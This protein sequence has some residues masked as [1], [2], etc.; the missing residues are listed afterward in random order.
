MKFHLINQKNYQRDFSDWDG[1]EVFP[2]SEKIYLR[3]E[4][5]KEE[6]WEK[7]IEIL[8]TP[9][10]HIDKNAVAMI[11]MGEFY[12]EKDC[13]LNEYG[14]PKRGAEN[15]RTVTGLVLDYDG[16]AK[17][18]D[19][20][21]Q[22]KNYEFFAYTSFNH[23]IRKAYIPVTESLLL[24][25]KDFQKGIKIEIE[26]KTIE[27]FRVILPFNT[28]YDKDEIAKRRYSLEQ[29]F[30]GADKTTF[31]LSRHFYVYSSAPNRLNNAWCYHNKGKFF[32]IIN[33]P[34]SRI[35]Y[36]TIGEPQEITEKDKLDV[37]N[38][39]QT[40]TNNSVHYNK[41]GWQI[42]NYC[43]TI[44]I[45]VDKCWELL[46]DKFEI[47]SSLTNKQTFYRIYSSGTLGKISISGFKKYIL[48]NGGKLDGVKI[49]NNRVKKLLEIEP[50]N[51]ER[52]HI[53]EIKREI[54]FAI[55]K[56]F[57]GQRILLK[58]E[59][60]TG[61]TK[62]AI[63]AI[64]NHFKKPYVKVFK[65]DWFAYNK[66]NMIDVYHA[67]KRNGINAII[68]YGRD[69]WCKH[70]VFAIKNGP[71]TAKDY[72]LYK[73]IQMSSLC[74][75]SCPYVN[76]CEYPKQFHKDYQVAIKH[77]SFLTNKSSYFDKESERQATHLVVDE[78][79]SGDGFEI[80]EYDYDKLPEVT[81]EVL[82]PFV[83][84]ATLGDNIFT[85]EL[86]DLPDE[87]EKVFISNSVP[88]DE[89]T[90][91]Q[92]EQLFHPRERTEDALINR[93]ESELEYLREESSKYYLGL[94]ECVKDGLDIESLR[95]FMTSKYGNKPY[96][97]KVTKM[98]L[99]ALQ[100]LHLGNSDFSVGVRGKKII[101]RKRKNYRGKW[102][103][104]IL[105]LDAT[106][107]TTLLP[108]DYEEYKSL[109]KWSPLIKVTQIRD[110][111][112]SKSDISRDAEFFNELKIF[113][114]NTL[115]NCG[116]IAFISYKTEVIGMM[117]SG[118]YKDY[119]N[120]L[121]IEGKL[122]V[123]WF[124]NVRGS[125]RFEHCDK[126]IILGQYT[127]NPDSLYDKS[128]IMDSVKPS[129]TKNSRLK[130][131]YK[132]K[133]G[134]WLQ[135]QD[136]YLIYDNPTMYHLSKRAEIDEMEQVIGRIRPIRVSNPKELIL[137]TKRP[138][139]I[140]IDELVTW[141]TLCK[142]IENK[143]DK[144]AKQLIELYMSDGKPR[145]RQDILQDL[146]DAFGYKERTAQEVWT[147]IKEWVEKT[148]EI[149]Y[150]QREGSIKAVAIYTK[151]S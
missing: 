96:S 60:G 14:K 2:H 27:K 41:G 151:K 119:Y 143:R 112:F 136:G 114:E 74:N 124:G 42:I 138:H 64:S 72:D 5:K 130:G 103:K 85:I 120:S 21:E 32:D 39:I 108:Y 59:P 115:K 16:G 36:E 142:P 7:I 122:I 92:L 121:I 70:E 106:A 33:V 46:R 68:V 71:S 63:E 28:A 49:E 89:I 65:L 109:T 9:E 95:T 6:S 111:T 34:V 117:L 126:L 98:L 35:E 52:K 30:I 134:N 57:R 118:Q 13:V 38:A 90:S 131:I 75:L 3:E 125:N 132:M 19:V 82:K 58:H 50:K 139:N 44:G 45:S 80:G 91:I 29:I 79:E 48:I 129:I 18:E 123:D 66:K 4:D 22:L 83:E 148:Y 17:W 144:D 61:K 73:D 104:P 81:K 140:P 78:A 135:Q 101:L 69:H 149:Q 128:C 47:G 55:T 86:S 113:I 141:K 56:W 150:V 20:K 84:F 8:S 88:A 51:D 147:N 12:T 43:K 1:M 100:N 116:S 94:H 97:Y 127:E 15:L 133:E 23:N 31:Y 102:R 77:H 105:M 137:L 99:N 145:T 93:L 11:C 67:F 10:I 54:V 146:M 76:E 40:I 107:D 62:E 87:I 110:R 37:C 24:S 25:H 26:D 53:N